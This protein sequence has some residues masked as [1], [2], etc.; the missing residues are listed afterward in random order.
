MDSLI[1]VVI[2]CICISPIVHYACRYKKWY[3]YLCCALYTILPDSCA[4]ELS[5]SLPLI[6]FKRIMIIALCIAFIY[7][8][9]SSNRVRIPRELFLYIAINIIVSILNMRNGFTEINSIFIMCL[10]QFMLVLVIKGNI[11][12]KDE[13]FR[14]IDFLIYG[15]V[16]LAIISIVQTVA[17][18]DISTVFAI[19]EAR[20]SQTIPDRMNTVRAF[21]TT[22]AI[23][24]GC[25]C[26]FMLFIILFMY[27]QRRKIKYIVCLGINAMALFC[28]MT[29]SALLAFAI[30]LCVMVIVRNY[31]LIKIYL[32]YTFIL[33]LGTI[34]VF[35]IKP[36][37]FDSIVEVFKS[38]LN[39]I[40]FNIELSE[41]FGANANSASY[42]RLVQWS[43]VYYMIR[44]GFMWLGY[45]YQ[46]YSR[47][48]LYYYF[49]HFGKWTK[50][51]ALDT[52]YVAIATERGIIG[53]ANNIIFWGSIALSSFRNRNKKEYDF[54]K[55]TLYIVLL[56][57]IMNVASAFTNNELIWMYIAFFF[58]YRELDYVENN[59]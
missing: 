28:T 2:L 17:K 51:T 16:V 30:V 31:Q 59:S 47:G 9:K 44:E 23:T 33:L 26:A 32:K 48:F 53:L 57:V 1:K 25:Y 29:R 37:I 39:V 43:A 35:L 45:G 20:V 41:E 55:L 13:L 7:N 34:V 5:G 14:C 27:E 11:S 21:G 38:I 22:N 4:I 12:D 56:Y 52:G 3:L 19:T 15:S 49:E 10:E 40:G 46:A 42:S 6:T 36:T 18:I 8:S 50:A 24:N 58:T 54:Y